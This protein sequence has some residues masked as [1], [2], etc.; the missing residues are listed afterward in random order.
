MIKTDSDK[1]I[2]H[3]DELSGFY[4]LSRL[5]IVLKSRKL[6]FEKEI[7]ETDKLVKQKSMVQEKLKVIDMELCNAWLYGWA[8]I[9]LEKADSR[10]I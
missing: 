5:N 10:R 2:K 1:L 3:K 7:L 9:L 8:S 6:R 4:F